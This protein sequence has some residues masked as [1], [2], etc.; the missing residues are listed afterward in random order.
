MTI[1]N[2]GVD[3]NIIGHN[4]PIKK[5]V[6]LFLYNPTTE[7]VVMVLVVFSIVLLM[8][9]IASPGTGG[10][11]GSFVRKTDSKGFMYWSELIVTLIFAIEYGLKIWVAPLKLRFIKA[12]WLDLMAIMPLMRVFRLGRALRMFR[13]FRLV[14]AIRM[15][16]FVERALQPKTDFAQKTDTSVIALYLIFAIIFGTIGIMI[17]EQNPIN[18]GFKTIWD[19]LWWCIVTL[20]TVGYGDISPVTYGGKIVAALIMFIGLSFYALLTGTISTMLIERAHS[21]KEDKL[22]IDNLRDHTVICGWNA[23]GKQLL[24]NLLEGRARDGLKA[25]IR[26][27]GVL[28]RRGLRC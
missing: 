11:M 26:S 10:M 19:G 2:M 1:R 18:D 24:E 8:L 15:G 4:S 28:A 22:R 16:S 12:T 21:K 17:F 23:Q 25:A 3:E 5:R 6:F 14:R 13:L 7:I 20:T 27:M 9:E